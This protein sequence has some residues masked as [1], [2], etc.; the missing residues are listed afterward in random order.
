MDNL[1]EYVGFVIFLLGG[2]LLIGI[3]SDYILPKL[4]ETFWNIWKTHT[5]YNYLRCYQCG[6]LIK[7]N[8]DCHVCIRCG[9]YNLPLKINKGKGE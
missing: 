8:E 2:I 1:V 3:F 6:R 4:E 5:E 7:D 9:R